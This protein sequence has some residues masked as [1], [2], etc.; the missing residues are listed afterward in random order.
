ME[1]AEMFSESDFENG[2][3]QNHVQWTSDNSIVEIMDTDYEPSGDI[4]NS[5]QSN[6]E[7]SWFVFSLRGSHL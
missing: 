2:E 7:V 5:N 1:D 4:I 6:V 3:Q